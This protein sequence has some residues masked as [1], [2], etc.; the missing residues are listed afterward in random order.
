MSELYVSENGDLIYDE[1]AVKT[2]PAWKQILLKIVIV[3]L[4]VFLA[5]EIAWYFLVLPST[6]QV[7]ITVAGNTRVGMDELCN[8]AGING[9]ETWM[10]FSSPEVAARLAAN[11]L[12]ERVR[13]EKHFPDRVVVT[14]TERQP[15]AL[16]FGLVN[17][18]TVPLEIDRAGIIFR[19][20]SGGNT[21]L[22]LLTGLTIENPVPGMR[23]DVQLR[24]L[25]EQLALVEQRNP[26]LAASLS[27]IKIEA[28]TYGGYDLV[29]YPVHTP[30]RV[31]T[32]RALNEASLQYMMLVL[33]V[34]QDLALDVDEIDIR[35]GT[36][37]Y[38]VKGESL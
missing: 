31:R 28:K 5:A 8:M 11:P 23:L 12:F 30:I 14:V 20:G 38:R 29:V 24:Q 7:R 19:I 32:D 36:V 25:L 6:T 33:D 21:N 18:R 27:E 9:S 13:V 35:A 16:A 10:R 22:P 15:V 17:G 1:E 3:I 4:V 26:V 37:A 2:A 34:V